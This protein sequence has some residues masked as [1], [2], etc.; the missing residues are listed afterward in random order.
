MSVTKVTRRIVEPRACEAGLTTRPPRIREAWVGQNVGEEHSPRLLPRTVFGLPPSSAAGEFLWQLRFPTIVLPEIPVPPVLSC[1]CR[2]LR[3]MLVPMP[4]PALL[5]AMSTFP[6]IVESPTPHDAVFE[7][8]S[9]FPPT[10]AC[11]RES[12]PLEHCSTCTL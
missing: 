2:F 12:A 5:L 1:T 9:T 11:S 8:H 6:A 4:T 10:V 3:T 7:S